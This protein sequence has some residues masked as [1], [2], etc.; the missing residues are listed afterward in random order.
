MRIDKRGG[1]EASH[2]FGVLALSRCSAFDVTPISSSGQHVI[3]ISCHC[4]HR[5][6]LRDAGVYHRGAPFPGLVF[7][8][9]GASR[10]RRPGTSNPA[11]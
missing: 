9:S 3:Q 4:T 11:A 1:F 10:R 5:G 7:T 8:S 6:N 2:I